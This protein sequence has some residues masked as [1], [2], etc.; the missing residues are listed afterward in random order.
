MDYI[1]QHLKVTKEHLHA[2]LE[3]ENYDFI[4]VDTLLMVYYIYNRNSP[5]YDRGL[6]FLNKLDAKL[7]R[8]FPQEWNYDLEELKNEVRNSIDPKEQYII[9]LERILTQEMIDCYGL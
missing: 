7:R 3:Q 4:D 8:Y 1:H 9:V 5:D 6:G 2:I